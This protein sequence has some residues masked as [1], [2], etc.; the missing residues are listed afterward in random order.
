[1]KRLILAALLGL[2]AAAVSA[3]DRGLPLISTI[4]AE[5]HVGGAQS[6]AVAQDAKGILYFGN[7]SGALVYDGA[8][9]RLVALP[10][11][12][13]VYSLATN[14]AGVVAAGGVGEFGV[15]TRDARGSLAYQSLV[16]R[17]P[18][19]QRNVGDVRGVCAAGN[20]FTFVTDEAL[21]AWDGTAPKLLVDFHGRAARPA[22]CAQIGG[23]TY[24]FGEL[25]LQRLL[26]GILLPAGIDNKIVDAAIDGDGKLIAAV[27][28]EGLFAIANG[29]ATPFAP[30]A[31]AWLRGKPVTSA[32]RLRDG[33]LVFTTRSDGALILRA[34]GAI[35]QLIDRTAGLPDEV[36]RASLEDRE[37]ALWLVLDGSLARVDLAS[38]VSLIDAR[39]GVRGAA[40]SASRI[41]DTL[42]ITTSHG[43][44]SIRNGQPAVHHNAL[45]P[46]SAWRVTMI[47]S[48][49]FA[50]T[51]DGLFIRRGETGWERVAGTAGTVVYA[52]E[53]SRR[54]PSSIWLGTRKGVATLRRDGDGWRYDG[55]IAGTPAYARPL[56]EHEGVLWAGSVF[57]GVARIELRPDGRPD[58][59]TFG[60]GEMSPAIIDQRMVFVRSNEILQ[61]SGGRML[62]DPILGHTST[63][64]AAFW[65]VVQ[66]AR[67]NVWLNAAPPRFLRRH[68]DGT[69][70]RVGQ[71][72]VSVRGNIQA[73]DVDPS[74]VVRMSTNRG[75]YFYTPLATEHAD[76]QPAP[77]IGRVLAGSNTP[78]A[79]GVAG[80]RGTPKLPYEFRRLRIEFAP[81][82]YGPGIAYQYRLDPLDS[83]WSGW[84]A[85][86]FIDYT[87]LPN[88]AYTLRLRARNANGSISP[89]TTWSF[90]VLP[91]WYRTKWAYALALLAAIALI[92]LV[93]RL[94]TRALQRQAARLRE[95]VELRTDALRLTV[96]RLR[97]TQSELVQNNEL[98]EQANERLERLSL[99]DELTGIPNRRYFDRVLATDYD[100]AAHAQQPLALILLDLDHFKNL[101]DEAG[102]PAGDACLRQVGRFLAQKI[103]RSGDM[104]TRSGDVVARIGGEEFAILLANTDTH[105][106]LTVAESLRFGIDA[107]EMQYEQKQLR[108]TASCGV[109]AVEPE[110][111]GTAEML[112]RAADRALYAAKAAGRNCVR[113]D[114]GNTALAPTA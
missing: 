57:E 106:A 80:S 21:I 100:A 88:G 102:H 108:I 59:R 112:I 87:H 67:G 54:D 95:L 99:L 40:N 31:S 60:K 73:M 47:G 105:G 33:R 48:D 37:G 68:A 23:A 20:E 22:N 9:W 64:G 18:Q 70:D 97:E 2:A 15:L 50:A 62:P 53:A 58:V 91:P 107:L 56:I 45:P 1:M 4:A 49:T 27:R 42:W 85:D 82:S 72:V 103:R 29:A 3:Q 96:R 98:L 43:V 113:V 63:A 11:D 10:N 104:V 5:Q 86:P 14:D 84:S 24:V 78:V 75:V 25:G 52:I 79:D 111:G 30:E 26:K 114:S 41:G 34:D 66:D 81:A 69:Y 6:F 65:Q 7:L 89:E 39:R 32:L 110:K 74:G 71:P 101:N 8:F 36:L 109:A 17:L 90:A 77:I 19:A 38:P 93:V 28:D 46:V 83:D 92:V 94:R 13:A 16:S 35:D 61:L 55:V 51:S 44:F 12:S 76:V